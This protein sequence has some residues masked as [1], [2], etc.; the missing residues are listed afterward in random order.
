MPQTELVQVYNAQTMLS[1][2]NAQAI[3][4]AIATDRSKVL[5]VV[6]GDKKIEPPGFYIPRGGT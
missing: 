3:M 1:N 6:I 5:G 2:E 4:A